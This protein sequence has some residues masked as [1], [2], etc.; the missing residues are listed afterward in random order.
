M[1]ERLPTFPALAGLI[2]AIALSLVFPGQALAMESKAGES[3][4]PYADMS[5]IYSVVLDTT[6]ET[7]PSAPHASVWTMEPRAERPSAPEPVPPTETERRFTFPFADFAD[8]L[9]LPN[10]KVTAQQGLGRSARADEHV[11]TYRL[12]SLDLARSVSNFGDPARMVQNL[13]GVGRPSDWETA[14][15]V[16]GGSPDQTAYLVDGIPISKVS[17]FEGLRN[18]R[19]GVGILSLEY[20]D[21]IEFH[22]GAFAAHLPDRMSGIVEVR[23]RDGDTAAHRAGLITDVTGAGVAAEGPMAFSSGAVGRGSYAGVFRYSTM[24]LLIRSGMLE[25]FGTPRYFNGQMRAYI[26]LGTSSLRLNVVG[27]NE[28]WFNGI[29]NSAVLDI[30]GTSLSGGATWKTGEGAAWTRLDAHF[31]QRS[32]ELD[33]H[34]LARSRSPGTDSLSQREDG[35]ENRFG[36]SADRSVPLGEHWVARLGGTGSL[37][38]GTYHLENMN[39]QTFIPEADTVVDLTQSKRIRVRALTEG[40]VYLEAV[41]RTETWEGYAGY[42]HFYEQAADRHGFGPRLGLKVRPSRSHALKAALGLHT[43]PHDY[44]ELSQRPEP[45]RAKLPYT[46]QAVLGYEWRMP[47]SLLLSIEAYGKESFRLSRRSIIS[48][49]G[50]YATVHSDTGRAR[51][52]G[53][54]LFLRKRRGGFASYSVAYNYLWHRELDAMGSWSKNEYSIPHSFNASLELALTK[55][56]FLGGR[57]CVASG[58]PYT[59]FDT[60]AS[61]RAGTGVYDPARAYTRSEATF[62]RLD[63]RLEWDGSIGKYRL[64]AFVEIE[65]VLDRANFFSR[66]WNAL[67]GGDIVLRGMERLPVAGISMDF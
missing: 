35:A 33:F 10:H 2:G 61:M 9:T 38:T 52:R 25:A 13:P 49:D 37:I 50:R 58:M 28:R 66:R 27:G 6:A 59:P 24:D 15:I 65:N 56:L 20:A 31:Q 14:L 1:P 11:G 64:T 12:A 5:G 21:G 4:E 51:S 46:A 34:T 44:M 8:T 17:H 23:Y 57:F 36:V 47:D 7:F 43:Q 42:R 63:A 32:Q 54:E 29:G 55:S 19:G 16:R 40:A 3:E 45:M 60:A 53:G 67:E 48:R 30:G 22:N 62:S 26:P 41:R 18:E 39:Q